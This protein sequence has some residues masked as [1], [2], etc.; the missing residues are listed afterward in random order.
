MTTVSVL[1]ALT[2]PAGTMKA[3]ALGTAN[4][5]SERRTPTAGLALIPRGVALTVKTSSAVVARKTQLV[6]AVLPL[7]PAVL[8]LQVLRQAV[9]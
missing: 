6:P 2:E 9:A 5:T 8:S 3:S 4:Y 7:L 1:G